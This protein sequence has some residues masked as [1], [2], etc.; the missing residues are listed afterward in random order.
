MRK[1]GTRSLPP[2]PSHGNQGSGNSLQHV[3]KSV[4]GSVSSSVKWVQ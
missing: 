4:Y 3:G 1:E 2:A